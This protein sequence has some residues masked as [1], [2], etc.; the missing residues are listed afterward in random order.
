MI[1]RII[2]AIGLLLAPPVA[3]QTNSSVRLDVPYVPTP[4]FVIKAML[5]LAKVG[6]DD[7]VYDLG[8]GDGR[9]VIDAVQTR[10]VKRAVGI[11]LNPV[12]VA[13]ANANAE[14]AGVTDRVTFT[15]GDVF[16]EDLSPATVVTM[17]LLPNVNLRLRPR[18]LDHLKPGTRV[19]S[20]AFHMFDWPPDAQEKVLGEVPIYMWI[21]PAKVQGTWTGKA[22]EGS[23]TFSLAQKFQV[24]SGLLT[25]EGQK[26]VAL[27]G[28]L[29][30]NELMVIGNDGVS[31]RGKITGA[32]LIGAITLAGAPQ[33]IVLTR[34]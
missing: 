23:F 18:L 4:P 26:P 2:L 34:Q 3:A 8:S 30:G 14:K 10:G 13:D 31:L 1:S 33:D 24:V 15:V 27:N 21:I 6:P 11:D 5:D 12:Q 32:T 19:V 16:K 25:R 9:I 22:G 7:V 17:Y 20:H 29:A 28:Q